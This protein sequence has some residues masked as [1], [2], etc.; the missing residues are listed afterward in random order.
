MIGIIHTAYIVLLLFFQQTAPIATRSS[1]HFTVTYDK[2]IPTADVGR[3]VD[4]L[5]SRF[6]YY[7]KNLNINP[8]RKL[9]V[10]MVAN[11]KRFSTI[12]PRALFEGGDF[13]DN[14]IILNCEQVFSDSEQFKYVLSRTVV[15]A[16]TAQLQSCPHWLGTAYGMYVGNENK[17][18]E[19]YPPGNV[20]ALSDLDE[21]FNRATSGRDLQQAY[22]ALNT[23]MRFL[24]GRYGE[25]KVQ[26]LFHQFDKRLLP[27]KAFEAALGEPFESIEEAWQRALSSK[28]K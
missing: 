4:S 28:R 6:L 8:A 9:A 15:T 24:I 10:R 22:S 7:R 19:A 11:E 5:E 26:A 27:V 2:E 14:K 1:D 23:T 18:F 3:M 12:V 21:T 16:M 13:L 20:F 17:R 25:R